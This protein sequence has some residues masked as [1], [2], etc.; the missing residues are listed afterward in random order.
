[1]TLLLLSSFDLIE[2][3]TTIA[4]ICQLIKLDTCLIL[5]LFS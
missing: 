2:S 3:F 4:W 1:M 5:G